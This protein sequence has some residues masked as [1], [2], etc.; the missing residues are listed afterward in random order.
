VIAER[1]TGNRRRPDQAAQGLRLGYTFTTGLERDLIFS[2]T[3]CH[4]NLIA[5]S[6]LDAGIL[7]FILSVQVTETVNWCRLTFAI[8]TIHKCHTPGLLRVL[9]IEECL[10]AIGLDDLHIRHSGPNSGHLLLPSYVQT[11]D[12]HGVCRDSRE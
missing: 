2:R 5:A 8:L 4:R 6:E 9:S 7:L 12:V 10:E 11:V 3:R 1:Q